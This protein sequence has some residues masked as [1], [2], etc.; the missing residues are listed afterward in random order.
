MAVAGGI[1]RRCGCADPGTGR[2]LGQLCSRLADDEHGSWY[3]RLEL[4]AAV[5]GR[6][7]RVRPGGY[8]STVAAGRL[9]Q[10]LSVITP[11]V[12]AALWTRPGVG[13]R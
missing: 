3:V 8:A 13:M 6:R 11:A 2:Q 1:H 9:R 12:V 10:M 5:D 4:P 7:R